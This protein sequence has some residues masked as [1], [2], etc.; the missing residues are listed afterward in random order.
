MSGTAGSYGSSIFSSLRNLHTVLHIGYTNLH[1]CQQCRRVSLIPPCPAFIACRFFDDGLSDLCEVTSHCNFDLHFCNNDVM[2]LFMCLL[3][4]CMK[5]TQFLTIQLPNVQDTIQVT[6]NIQTQDNTTKNQENQN[7][8]QRKRQPIE[9]NPEMI[10]MLEVLH[11]N[12]KEIIIIM[13]MR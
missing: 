2:Y 4:I 8:Y 10:Q 1:S 12:F 11:Y 7:S 5:K 13:L 9:E 3:A 6:Q